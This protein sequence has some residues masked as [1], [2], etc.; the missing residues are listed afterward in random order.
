MN[1]NTIV[2][3]VVGIIII[4][5]VVV[6]VAKQQAGSNLSK[7]DQSSSTTT[8][9]TT[10]NE[11]VGIEDIVV[12]TGTEAK[13]GDTIT[14]HYIGSLADGTQFESSYDKGQPA[15]FVLAKGQ[16]IDGWVEGIP[17]MKVGGKRKLTIPAAKGYGASGSG[18]IPP[19][20][21]LVFEIE[22]ISIP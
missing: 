1:K 10:T 3:L 8:E 22:L 5:V 13:E 17:G 15:T 2:A 21:D 9:Q 19:N 20:A 11:P 7:G 12:G 14:V 4:C 6:I 18:S 16:L